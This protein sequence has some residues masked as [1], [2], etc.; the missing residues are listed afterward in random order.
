MTKGTQI[1]QTDSQFRVKLRIL[2]PVSRC[3]SFRVKSR[4]ICFVVFFWHK[5]N[6][7]IYFLCP[8][9]KIELFQKK[10]KVLSLISKSKLISLSF[11]S[12]LP[13]SP[14]SLSLSVLSSFLFPPLFLGFWSILELDKRVKMVPHMLQTLTRILGIMGNSLT[15]FVKVGFTPTFHSFKVGSCM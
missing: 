13:Y 11:P 1:I 7:T 2:D 9:I 3:S 8:W 10:A 14:P 4:K 12:S 15:C 6:G 5:V